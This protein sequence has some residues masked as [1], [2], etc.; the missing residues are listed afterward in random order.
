MYY[1]VLS[2]I[3]GNLKALERVIADLE[4]YEIQG[5]I[6]LGDLIDY[7]TRSNEVIDL[8]RNALE[9]KICCNIWGNHEQAIICADYRR[10]S[11][12]RG[13]K[14]AQYT[15]TVLNVNSM[16]YIQNMMDNNGMRTMMCDHT[17]ILAVHGSLNDCFWGSITPE[18]VDGDYRDYDI[19]FSG[20]SHKSHMFSKLYD[21]DDPL[22]RNKHK[23]LFINPGSVGQP[24]NHNCNAQ[25]VLLDLEN[26]EVVFRSIPY[27]IEGAMREFDGSVDLFYRDRLRF[28]I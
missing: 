9:H 22:R 11:T 4:S 15:S 18:D 20:H 5:V 25:Y 14:C 24:R 8:I 27:D 6:I 10:F 1:A 23:V 2:D 28:G 13:V 17:R 16:D 21:A 26:M 12:E 3:H 19:V 7:G